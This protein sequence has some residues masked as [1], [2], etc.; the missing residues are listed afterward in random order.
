MFEA[1]KS[2]NYDFPEPY[3]NDIS[4][5]AIDFVS[6]LIVCVSILANISGLTLKSTL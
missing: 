1:I 3:W 4:P 5:Q 6:K 2:G